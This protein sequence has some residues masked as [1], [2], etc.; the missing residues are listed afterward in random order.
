[1]ISSVFLD[2]LAASFSDFALPSSSFRR[3][4]LLAFSPSLHGNELTRAVLS[5]A[6][7]GVVVG[8][9]AH[10]AP[11]VRHPALL[12]GVPLVGDQLLLPVAEATLLP[13][14]E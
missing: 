9:L 6:K 1:L 11:A 3:L 5:P 13:F 2:V 7:E 8:L 4:L 14:E 12:A 10:N